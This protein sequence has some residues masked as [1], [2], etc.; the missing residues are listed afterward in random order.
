MNLL[1]YTCR[2]P[3]CQ[4]PR[5][6]VCINS[7]SLSECPDVIPIGEEDSAEGTS[8]VPEV[9]PVSNE[10]VQT[11]GV[12][13]LDAAA[14]DALLRA[15]GGTVVAIVAG[16]EVGK[17]TMIAT[18]YEL[19]HRGRLT[20][21]RFAGSETLRGYEERCHLSRMASNAA[22]S[23]TPHTPISA[24]LSFTHLKVAT[25]SGIKDVIFSDRSGEHFDNALKRPSDI[26]GFAELKRADIIL[27]LVDL[28]QLLKTPHHPTSQV[29]RLFMAMEQHALLENKPVR[30]VGTKADLAK[31]RDARSE[32]IS[33]LNELAVDL[34]RRTVGRVSVTSS[35]IA[36]RASA[37]STQI[38]EG[39]EALIDEI[40]KEKEP[41]NF[42]AGSSWPEKNTELDALMHV[43]RSKQQ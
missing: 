13:S 10:L 33:A 39:F 14:C 34:S 28:E 18:M 4:G 36:S 5:S 15:R 7:L 31:T 22:R 32:A 3:G 12:S 38:G 42:C 6:G 8:V 30:L 16:P 17:T 20:A 26:A 35:L 23:D 24:K 40:L 43:Y 11:G 19:I 37:G 41:P 9:D 27:L 2:I 25:L 21:Y 1:A 29:R